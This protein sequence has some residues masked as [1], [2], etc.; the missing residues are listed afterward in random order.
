MKERDW[1]FD[2]SPAR[3][4]RGMGGFQAQAGSIPPRCSSRRG[5]SVFGG[6]ASCRSCRVEAEPHVDIRQRTFANTKGTKRCDR[7]VAPST[8]PKNTSRTHRRRRAGFGS[9]ASRDLP[10]L[11][12]AVDA[13]KGWRKKAGPG[14]GRERRKLGSGP[15]RPLL[16]ARPSC[17]TSAVSF[18]PPFLQRSSGRSPSQQLL[19]PPPF[20][21]TPTVGAAFVLANSPSQRPDFDSAYC[22]SSGHPKVCCGLAV[23][24][25]TCAGHPERL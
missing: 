23:E 1:W 6:A 7:R 13:E 15:S 24:S 18:S 12:V 14:G 10:L 4:K 17:S 16:F 11:S 9:A 5:R 19:P 2:V 8:Q 21:S 25:T 3:Q 22:R 20:P